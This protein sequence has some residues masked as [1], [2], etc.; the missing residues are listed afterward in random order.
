LFSLIGCGNESSNNGLTSET[1]IAQMKKTYAN[2][3]T[4]QDTGVVTTTFI[5]SSGN[6]IDE[7][8]FSTAF[9]RAD[10]FRYEYKETQSSNEYRYIIW[11]NGPEVLSW[12]DVTPGIN[13]EDSLD[14]AIAGATG[15][16]G[17]SAHTISA[18][19]LS[20]EISG[21]QLTDITE[22]QRIDNA[23]IDGVNCYRIQGKFAGDP[24]T[25]W[26][27][28]ATFLVRRIETQHT[29]S[30]FST[31]TVTTYS[32]ILNG[33]I[34]DA[35][36]AFNPPLANGDVGDRLVIANITPA[37]VSSNQ[38]TTFTVEVS[39]TL[40]SNDTGVLRVSD[41]EITVSR[42]SGTHIFNVAAVPVDADSYSY[43]MVRVTL[44][45]QQSRPLAYHEKFIIVSPSAQASVSPK[46]T[47]RELR[48]RQRVYQ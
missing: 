3:Q 18:L 31:E 6:W 13:T 27:E 17:G 1:I 21:R 37:S 34:T 16:S 35:I 39:Y 48:N 33:A 5:Q 26:I 9:V 30:N 44:Y 7:K 38:T 46:T 36:L 42:G 28:A 11:R 23:A 12:W 40:S 24:M 10:R 20:D 8:P 29:F 15:V 19:L 14:M 32:P 22:S 45:D 43:F 47:I 41:Q 25:I 4:Y 2:S